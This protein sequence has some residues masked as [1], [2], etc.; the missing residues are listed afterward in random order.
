[1]AV[2]YDAGRALPVETVASWMTVASRHVGSPRGPILDLGA[3]TGRFAAALADAFQVPVLAVEPAAAMRRQIPTAGSGAPVWVVGGRGELLPVADGSL[4]V[5]W[6][7]QVVHH[8]DDLPRCAT[9]LRRVL[10]P[11]G[12]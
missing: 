5:V 1:M 11:G 7:S 2:V 9:E 8:I 10:R 3:G 6:A 12:S 4:D